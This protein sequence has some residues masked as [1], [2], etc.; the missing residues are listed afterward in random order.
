MRSP[1][2]P[3]IFA[4]VVLVATGAAWWTADQWLPHARPWLDKTW[5]KLSRP[6]EDSLPPEKKAAQGGAAAGAR[7]AASAPVQP[8]KCIQGGRTT[9]TDQ[10][11]PPGSQEQTVDGSVTSFPR[12]P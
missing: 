7:S 11:C 12:T 8:R 2:R 3:T 5:S 9:Y 10:P 6:G 1:W 4:L